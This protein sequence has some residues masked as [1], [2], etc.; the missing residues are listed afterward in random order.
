MGHIEASKV[1]PQLTCKK[2]YGRGFYI[3]GEGFT[4]ADR[5][6]CHKC[7]GLGKVHTY[8][9]KEKREVYMREYRKMRKASL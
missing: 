7:N 2:C 6:H 4:S 8:Y 3:K 1:E 9:S 5:V